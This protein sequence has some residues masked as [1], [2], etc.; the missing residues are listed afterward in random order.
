V[1][2]TSIFLTDLRK[3]RNYQRGRDSVVGLATR[4]FGDRN[5]LGAR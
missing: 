3:I 4:W 5:P 1:N 2:E